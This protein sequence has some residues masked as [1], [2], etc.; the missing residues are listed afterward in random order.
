MARLFGLMNR[1]ALLLLCLLLL[2]SGF[3]P[4]RRESL[5]DR[6]AYRCLVKTNV[7]GGVGCGVL[8]GP[9]LVL[10]CAHCISDEEG[11][12]RPG[13]WV[14]FGSQRVSVE[15]VYMK[16]HWNHDPSSGQD[17]ALLKLHL[18]LGWR[19]GWLK[20]L[21]LSP[22]KLS[23]LDVEFA[24]FSNNPGEARPEFA[25]M[26]EPYRCAGKVLDVGKAIVFHDCAMW[27]GGSGAPLLHWDDEGTAQVV[28]VNT[29]GVEVEGE[30]LDHGFR[31]EF[32]QALANVA[33]PARNWMKCLRAIPR[34][35]RPAFRQWEVENS[36]DQPLH[37]R[38]RFVSLFQDPAEVEGPWQEIEPG[39]TL[40]L[41][42]DR[43]GCCQTSLEFQ[44]QEQGPWTRTP[45]EDDFTH[46][47]LPQ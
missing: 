20:C 26:K 34:P 17:W 27:G 31:H 29:A 45:L 19:E 25:E 2:G 14:E 36:S 33:V 24:G 43:D 35:D 9:D 21:S 15:T 10:T 38:I 44:C 30:I 7:Q 12:I 8:V 32:T 3:S 23:G 1:L 41:L 46:L 16:P 4:D 5:P 47:E 42:G 37:L 13:G 40:K 28:A 18:P 22:E 39:Q 11:Q 6:A